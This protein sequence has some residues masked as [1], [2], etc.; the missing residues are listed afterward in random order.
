VEQWIENQWCEQTCE[1]KQH[2]GIGSLEPLPGTLAEDDYFFHLNALHLLRHASALR[3]TFQ[4]IPAKHLQV[5]R[6]ASQGCLPLY[7]LPSES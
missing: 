4:S 3:L 2:E 5:S 6:P 7:N 1:R